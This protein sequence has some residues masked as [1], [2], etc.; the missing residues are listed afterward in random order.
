MKIN[1]V[2]N[3]IY[4]DIEVTEDLDVRLLHIGS[5]KSTAES[6]ARAADEKAQKYRLVEIHE[7]GMNQYIHHGRKHTGS[8]P[9]NLLKY[10]SHKD[11]RNSFG[12]KLEIIQ[13][14]NGL[15]VVSHIQFYDG[16]SVIRSWTDVSNKSNEN[17]P[18]EYVSS[19]AM[20]GLPSLPEE[21]RDK[22]VIV[23][24]PHSTWYG[25]AQWK[26]YGIN[27]LGYDVVNDKLTG[28]SVK[29]ISCSSTGTW[30]SSEHL[31]M[32]SFENAI[33]GST[34][35]WQIETSGSWYWEI[36]DIEEAL[37]LNISGPTY[38]ESHFLKVLKPRDTFH[39]VECA[40]AFVN[41]DFEKSIQELTKY[42]RRIRRKNPDNENPSV[43]FNDYMNCLFGDPTTEKLIPLIDAA[44][45]AGC[46]Y[47]CIDCGWYSD[48]YWW[49]GVGE[50]LPSEMRFPG[51]IKEPL[52]YIRSKGMIPGLWLEIEVMGIKCPLVKK[53]PEDWFFQRNGRPVISEGRYQLDFR[54]PEVVRHADS[55]IKRLVEEYGVGY[56]KMDYNINA[57]PGTEK[58]A[59]SPGDGLLQHNRAYLKW[60]DGIF[61]K[62][63]DLV[64][65]NCGSGGMRMEYSLLSRHSI[66][67][68]TDQTDYL[69]MAAIAANTMT[70][71]TPEQA[72]IW[73][74]P[75]R[76]GDGEEAI[77]NMVNAILLRIHQSGHLAEMSDE[78]MKYIKEGISYHK[79]ISKELKEGLP[80]WPLGLASFSDENVCV[81]IECKNK[82][83]VAVWKVR[84]A[85]KPVKIHIKQAAG[86][87]ANVR[88]AY[89][90]D[91]PVSFTWND[92]DSSLTATLNPKTAR[93]FEIETI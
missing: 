21:Q 74:Y 35:T 15:F 75:L 51:G 63:P 3:G 26:S 22:G 72:A 91:A 23:H 85:P 68:V 47:F 93:V 50:W 57:G 56:I 60:L 54:N 79:K 20:T 89:P 90:V 52:D 28:S 88:C 43:I 1:I 38:Q 6:K 49:D 32:G 80:F 83:Y 87:K 39:S 27:E 16:I 36:S 59:D 18:I 48:G 9:G 29:R 64:I 41:G 53:V 5:R 65:E 10:D 12:R 25:E 34:I 37:Y 2:E 44:C 76:D 40:V 46:K 82:L 78:R 58:D 13:Q 77:F 66:Q 33:I 8:C 31:P 14:Y 81:G 62:Y 7:T 71:V 11:Y 19:F 30:A 45:E 55:V 4:I 84:G 61:E 24:I 69:K 92:R 17:H 86:K 73:S 67:S 70:A 42:R